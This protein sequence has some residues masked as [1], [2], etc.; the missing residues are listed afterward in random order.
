MRYFDGEIIENQQLGGG[1]FR[2]GIDGCSALSGTRPGQFAMMHHA[3]DLA[4]RRLQ[5]HSV[6]VEP[7]TTYLRGAD[8][9]RIGRRIDVRRQR[10]AVEYRSEPGVVGG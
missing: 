3:V 7:H 2:L 4:R 5:D 9:R 10:R 1:Y 6:A 8:E